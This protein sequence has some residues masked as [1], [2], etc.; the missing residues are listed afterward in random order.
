MLTS[1]WRGGNSWAAPS[2]SV[3]SK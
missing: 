2:A 1:D 3:L